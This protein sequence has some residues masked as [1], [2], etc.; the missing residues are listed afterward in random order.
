MSQGV[1][2]FDLLQWSDADTAA[3]FARAAKRRSFGAGQVIYAQ[4]EDGSEMFRIVSGLVRLSVGRSDAREVVFLFFEP[5]DCFGVSSLIDGGPRPQTAE[6]DTGVALEVLDLTAFRRLREKHRSFDD[7]LL[8]LLAI[9]MRTISGRYADT[10][11]NGLRA[12]IATRIIE[13]AR[14][15]SDAGG[16]IQF[17]LRLSQTELAAMVGA[18]RQSVN[19]ELQRLQTEGLVGLE[20]GNV[21]VH[22]APA[23]KRLAERG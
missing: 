8:R 20:Y 1:S 4:G 6:A 23:L 2:A 18:S 7:A 5:G 15:R 11:L 3:A 16:Q 19:K 10:S 9:Q 14:P 21:V 13:T 12:R 22:D 17:T